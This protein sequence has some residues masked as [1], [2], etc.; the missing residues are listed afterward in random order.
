MWWWGFEGWRQVIFEDLCL[1]E[2][3]RNPVYRGILKSAECRV[4]SDKW[5]GLGDERK[6][7]V[8]GGETEPLAFFDVCFG[9]R[10]GF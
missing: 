9:W 7:G 8:V 4:P 5:E 3:C 10:V 1:Q 2:S 6:S